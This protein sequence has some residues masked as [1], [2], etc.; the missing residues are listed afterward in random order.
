MSTSKLNNFYIFLYFEFLINFLFTTYNIYELSFFFKK[1]RKR[2]K[3][4]VHKNFR[5][6]WVKKE[7]DPKLIVSFFNKKALTL[8]NVETK[9]G[10]VI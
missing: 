3:E 9:V 2:Q 1:K 8:M 5:R 7:G 4:G 6:F 10:D